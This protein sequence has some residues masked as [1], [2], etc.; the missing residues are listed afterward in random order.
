M[1][2]ANVLAGSRTTLEHTSM[3]IHIG[4]RTEMLCTT[5]GAKH[6]KH[7]NTKFLAAVAAVAAHGVAPTVLLFSNSSISSISLIVVVDLVTFSI[8]F[9]P[10]VC[11]CRCVYPFSKSKTVEMLFFQSIFGVC[12]CL[13]CVWPVFVCT[14][15]AVRTFF[16][17]FSHRVC[18]GSLCVCVQARESVFTIFSLGL[19]VCR[20]SRVLFGLQRALCIR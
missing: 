10:I 7:T 13:R 8:S 3:L 6:T 16:V 9:A 11:R 5:Y 18:D 14:V 15:H 20:W 4:G 12:K 17:P 2:N 19:F 1:L